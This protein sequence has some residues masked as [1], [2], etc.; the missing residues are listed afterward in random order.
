MAKIQNT[1]NIKCWQG[2]RAIGTI[3]HCWWECKMIQSLWKTVLWF[4]TRTS[5]VAQTV[6][7]LP[8]EQ[9][10]RVQSL[11]REDLLEKEMATHSSILAWEIS[12]TVEP[13]RLQSTGLQRVGHDWA[14][15]T[16]HFSK[17][18]WANCDL[19]AKSSPLPDFVNK[20][21]LVHSPAHSFTYCLWLF[22]ENNGRGEAFQSHPTSF[23]S[24]KA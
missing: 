13:G 16:F 11:G 17:Q 21:L 1:D 3:I 2:C 5:L 8:I 20:N 24:H 14:T 10:T 6:K 23:K 7:Y 9:E 18:G 12:W 22:W 15:N 19:L 4:P